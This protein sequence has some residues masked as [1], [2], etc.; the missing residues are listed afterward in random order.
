MHFKMSKKAGKAPN[1]AIAALFPIGWMAVATAIYLRGGDL[2]HLSFLGA[3]MVLFS[4]MKVLPYQR[5]KG[6]WLKPTNYS[7]N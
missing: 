6:V 2:K 3:G 7:A 1:A 5:A 4:M